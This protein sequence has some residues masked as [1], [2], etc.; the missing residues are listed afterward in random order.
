MYVSMIELMKD[1][2][3]NHYCIPATAVENEHTVR[4]CIMAAEEKNSPI[5]LISLF[6]TNPD[7]CEFG[8]IV[9]DI[10]M[11]SKVPVAMCQDH[12][13]TYEEAMWAIHAGFTD[14]MVDR[15]TLPF[16]ENAAQVK[17]L[18]KAAHAV[19]MGVEAELGHVVIG[20]DGLGVFT[21]PSEAKKFVEETGVD[22][23]AVSIGTTHGQ[24]KGTPHLKFDLLK[25]LTDTLDLPLVLHGGSGTGDENL[26]KASTMGIAKLNLS[27]DLKRSAIRKLTSNPDLMGM[28]AYQ[29]YPLLTE[30]YKE[31]VMRYMDI[32]GSTGKA[33]NFKF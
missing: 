1:A 7:I 29:M 2:Y 19:G 8:R 30:G 22:A 26:K 12:G 16:E 17:E 21:I 33:D 3:K 20:D 32:T 15:S 31:E 10:A 6:K 11:K 14:I 25:E 28:G 13:G 18:V 9:K 23:L 4:A 27:N 24:Y 5:I